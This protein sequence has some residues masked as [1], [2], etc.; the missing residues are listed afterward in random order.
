MVLYEL[1]SNARKYG[2]LSRDEGQLDLRWT[3]ETIENAPHLA[4]DWIES[5][6]PLTEKPPVRHFGTRLIETSLTHALHGK[7]ELDF[8]PKGLCCRILLPLR[9]GI[10]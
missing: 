10:A 1:G 4:F 8:A 5:G 3:V 6:G 7:V 2:A 9:P